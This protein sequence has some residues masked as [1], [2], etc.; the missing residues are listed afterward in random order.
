MW[1]TIAPALARDFTVV[2]SDLRSYGDSSKPAGQT[3]HANYSFRVMAQDQIEVMKALGHD[4]FMVVGHDRGARVVHRMALDHPAAV[5]KAA[6]LDIL[7]TLTLYQHTDAQ[8]AHIYWE[9]F[10]LH[11]GL[12]LPGDP[13]RCGARTLLAART[14]RAARPR[15]D[16][17][18]S[19]GLDGGAH[20]SVVTG[21]ELLSGRCGPG[22]GGHGEGLRRS[23]GDAAGAK[24]GA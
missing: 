6:V 13:D 20:P 19:L 21:G 15:G 16:R 3:D 22:M 10:F 2:A 9:W 7:P 1:H 11:P 12:R 18:A 24:P 4:T 8:F 5:I 23:H 17:E 14:R